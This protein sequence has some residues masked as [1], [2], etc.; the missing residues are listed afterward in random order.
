MLETTARKVQPHHLAREACLYVRQSSLK[1]VACHTESAHRQYGLRRNAI[2]LGWS[3]ERIRV[4]DD[5]QGKSGAYS[6]NRSG[7][8]DLMARIA[9][10]EVGIVL[11]LEV[12]RLARDNCDW[13]QLLQVARIADTL[14][15]D[16]SGVHDPRD[17]SDKLLLDIKGTLSEFE[18]AGIRARLLGGQRSKA[19]RGEL[20]VPLPIGLAYDDQGQ[21]AFDPDRQVVEAIRVVFTAFRDKGSAMQVVKW[22]RAEN[23]RLPTRASSGP[24]RGLVRWSLP[25]HARIRRILKNPSYAGAFTYGKTRTLRQADGSVRYLTLSPEQWEICIPEHHAGFIDWDEYCRNLQRLA[26]NARSF[27]PSPARLSAPR[28]GAALLQGLVL[29][30]H[31][32]R[33]MTVHYTNARPARNQPAKV[34]YMC[35]EPRMRQGRKPCQSIRAEG[36]DAA[37]ARFALAAMNRENIAIALA[38]QEQVQTEFAEA[39]AQRALRIE[40]LSYEAE[41]AQ[42][43][44]YA[45]DPVNRLVAAP[46]EA[47]WNERLR[48]LE[49]AIRERDERREIRDEEMSA[50]QIRRVEALASDFAQVWDASGTDNADRKRLLGLLVEDVTLTRDGYEASI[51][52][53]LRGGKALE[54]DP[55]RL[56][57]PPHLKRPLCP[58]TVA[59][60]DTALDTHSDTEAAEIL[61][62]AGHRRWNGAPFTVRHVYRLRERAN[63][64][65]H[66]ERRQFRLRA[67]GYLTAGELAPQL[68]ISSSRLCELGLQGRI[69][70]AEIKTGGRPR[71]MYKLP[72]GYDHGRSVA[73]TG[74]PPP[75]G[76]RAKRDA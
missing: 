44:Y 53:Q 16:E 1:Q 74:S 4:I 27:A 68:G 11:S 63:L 76:D 12:S 18:L 20:R 8:R 10:G 2:A 65:G 69:L 21:I 71:T 62:Q 45:V 32:G 26:R 28:N 41:L 48:E 67:Q 51:A 59:A 52:L 22:F 46:L 50:E 25:D 39:D 24:C 5:D 36:V 54:L 17:S 9:A 7:F 23:I 31:C 61:N 42:R 57:R 29:C 43:R 38:V 73:T 70:R 47:A 49:E 55:V 30:G 6:A 64:K 3:E 60:L 72:P 13:G 75:S 14:I 58:A 40:R 19:A 66:G 37:V 35:Q 15:L 33:R 56:N 34:H